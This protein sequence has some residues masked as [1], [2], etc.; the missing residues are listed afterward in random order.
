[1]DVGGQFVAAFNEAGGQSA[2]SYSNFIRFIALMCVL[3]STLWS[4]YHFMTPDARESENFLVD[5]SF[6]LVRI[7]IGITLFILLITT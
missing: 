7:A 3:L 5:A 2:L 4:I 6:R 1:M